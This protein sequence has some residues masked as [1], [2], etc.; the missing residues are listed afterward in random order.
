M[1]SAEKLDCQTDT[2]R[3][4][5]DTTLQVSCG[6][7]GFRVIKPALTVFEQNHVISSDMAILKSEFDKIQTLS[8]RQFTVDA[9]CNADGSNSLC[10]KFYSRQNSFLK[11]KLVS[12]EH[13]WM[14]APFPSM[15]A[16]L[17]HYVQSKVKDPTI[18]ACILVPVWKNCTW[19]KHLAGMELL[20]SYPPGSV[21]FTQPKADGTRQVMPGIP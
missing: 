19:R 10:K 20:V 15:D 12:G 21:L 14:N 4:L 17:K 18:S 6:K 16:S 8:G 3:G 9:F 1:P 2:K 5:F 13:L 11:S 7:T